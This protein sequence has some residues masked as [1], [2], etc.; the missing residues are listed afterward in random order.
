[1]VV[2]GRTVNALLRN[3]ARG[4]V[5]KYNAKCLYTGKCENRLQLL[6]DPIPI[7]KNIFI[8]RSLG[9]YRPLRYQLTRVCVTIFVSQETGIF[10]HGLN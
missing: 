4:S 1:M 3:T 10:N 6:A 7:L 5:T 9:R 2:F 8:L